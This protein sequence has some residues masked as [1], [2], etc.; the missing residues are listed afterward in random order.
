[1][2]L[3]LSVEIRFNAEDKPLQISDFRLQIE[4]FQSAICN[5]QSAI[6]RGVYMPFC[7]E[8]ESEYQAGITVCSSCQV[9]LVEELPKGEEAPLEDWVKVSADHDQT[10]AFVIK[11]FLENEGI[12][13]QLENVTFDAMPTTAT[14]LVNIWVK[15]E[16]EARAQG[17]LLE[18]EYIAQCSRCGAIC[19]LSDEV[20]PSCGE[21]LEPEAE[22]Q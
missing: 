10:E 9:P 1:M 8:C 4:G 13:C 7:P 17:L 5:L 18:H 3:S 2:P 21:K 12:E 22:G 16:D 11:G 15:K 20:C 6:S 19:S 14:T